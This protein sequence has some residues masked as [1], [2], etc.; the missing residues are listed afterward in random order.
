M[1]QDVTCLKCRHVST[2]FEPFMDIVLDVLEVS[3]IEEALRQHF[4]PERIDDDMYRRREGIS[5]SSPVT[6]PSKPMARQ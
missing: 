2:T 4:Q 1:R 5:L 6:A 3:T